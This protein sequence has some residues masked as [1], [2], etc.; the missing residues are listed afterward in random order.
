MGLEVNN[1]KNSGWCL[2]QIHYL[3]IYSQVVSWKK[4]K[5]TQIYFYNDNNNLISKVKTWSCLC[6]E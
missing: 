4:I 3:I 2:G 1:V 5:K 6:S